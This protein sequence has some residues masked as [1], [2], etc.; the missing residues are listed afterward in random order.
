MLFKDAH[1]HEMMRA[2]DCGGA[3][4]CDVNALPLRRPGIA[5]L[6]SPR[7]RSATWIKFAV[8]DVGGELRGVETLRAGSRSALPHGPAGR[9]ASEPT[10][11]QLYP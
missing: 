6:A 2:I 4:L 10:T 1:F 7:L 5:Y 11:P 3:R 8:A 9:K